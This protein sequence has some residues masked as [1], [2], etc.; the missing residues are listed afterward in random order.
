MLRVK[1]AFVTRFMEELRASGLASE[2]AFGDLG[3][4]PQEHRAVEQ[5]LENMQ[6]ELAGVL[7]PEATTPSVVENSKESTKSA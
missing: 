2:V 6:R 7:F 5:F 1:G 3:T 4:S